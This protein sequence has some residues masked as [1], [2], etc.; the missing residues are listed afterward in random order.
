MQ[1]RISQIGSFQSSIKWISKLLRSSFQELI[2]IIALGKRSGDSHTIRFILLKKHYVKFLVLLVSW[3]KKIKKVKLGD[4]IKHPV[5]CHQKY[6][7]A[8]LTQTLS[9]VLIWTQVKCNYI[10]M[11]I[12]EFS[13]LKFMKY[14]PVVW[15]YNSPIANFEYCILNNRTKR[16]NVCT[17]RPFGFQWER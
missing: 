7:H 11:H 1:I 16:R 10:F 5:F 4:D 9:S 17:K 3:K 15:F 14:L 8:Q 12:L 6:C 2:D 13:S